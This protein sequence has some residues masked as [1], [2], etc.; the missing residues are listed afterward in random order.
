MRSPQS[1]PPAPRVSAPARLQCPLARL[2]LCIR[3][4][5]VTALSSRGLMPTSSPTAAPQKSG[6]PVFQGRG[7]LD[8]LGSGE[9]GAALLAVTCLGLPLAGGSV[10]QTPVARQRLQESEGAFGV[11]ICFKGQVWRK[12]R[13]GLLCCQV[14]CCV[15]TSQSQGQGRCEH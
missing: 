1:A 15:L 12:D 9:Q 2:H 11:L 4:G 14:F 8:G 13:S 10:A 7:K 6:C 5:L 3:P